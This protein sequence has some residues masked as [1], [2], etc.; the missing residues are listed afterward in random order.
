MGQRDTYIANTLS[1][2]WIVVVQSNDPLAVKKLQLDNI[3]AG[4]TVC[5]CISVR[6]LLCS[7]S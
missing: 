7:V 5:G 1:G 2:R 3:C 4:Y 6:L